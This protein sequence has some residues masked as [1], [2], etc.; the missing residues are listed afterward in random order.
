MNLD[1]PFGM[2][3]KCKKNCKKGLGIP[4]EATENREKRVKQSPSLNVVKENHSRL[5]FFIFL[6]VWMLNVVTWTQTQHWWSQQKG[7]SI[8]TFI[9]FSILLSSSMNGGGVFLYFRFNINI[10]M[11]LI[12]N[13]DIN[14]ILESSLLAWT[15]QNSHYYGIFLKICG[16]FLNRKYWFRWVFKVSHFTHFPTFNYV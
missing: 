8:Q 7:N 4:G 3:G 5:K 14:K 11:N 9:M 13:Q 15:I 10:S 16:I 6:R 1:I 2:D 12:Y